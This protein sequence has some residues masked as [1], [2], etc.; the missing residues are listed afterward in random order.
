M[1]REA[2]APW[3]G[4]CALVATFCTIAWPFLKAKDRDVRDASAD[5][6]AA[7]QAHLIASLQGELDLKERQLGECLREQERLRI[8]AED[9]LATIERLSKHDRG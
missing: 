8:V 9:R 6:T 5:A 4:I 2:V 7:S 3:R 1:S